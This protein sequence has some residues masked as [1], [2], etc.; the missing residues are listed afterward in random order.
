MPSRKLNGLAKALTDSGEVS[1]IMAF[2]EDA[3][4]SDLASHR[5][6]IDRTYGRVSLI[7]IV[8]ALAA[9]NNQWE[10]ETLTALRHVSPFSAAATFGGAVRR[11]GTLGYSRLLMYEYR[12]AYRRPG[13]R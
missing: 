13:A 10:R 3:P 11:G 4:A 5:E 6:L 12:F 8:D 7:D 9:G 1:T 2:S